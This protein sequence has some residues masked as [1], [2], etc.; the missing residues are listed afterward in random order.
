MVSGTRAK[1]ILGLLRVTFCFG[2]IAIGAYTSG[3]FYQLNNDVFGYQNPPGFFSIPSLADW[4]LAWVLAMIFWSG[5][6]F[7]TIGKKIDYILI[8]LFLIFGLWNYLYTDNVTSQMYLGFIGI[9]L[10]GNALGYL[11]KLARLRWVGR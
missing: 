9:A 11:L 5:I 6:F 10:L 7:G 1:L 4:I 2:V 3:P 8:S